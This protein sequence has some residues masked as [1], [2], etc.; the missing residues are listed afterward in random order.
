M[1]RNMANEEGNIAPEAA[2][3]IVAR[4]NK[5]DKK[6]K[7][8]TR[9]IMLLVV[10]IATLGIALGLSSLYLNRSVDNDGLETRGE[11]KKTKVLEVGPSDEAGYGH[12]RDVFG[13]DLSIHSHGDKFT[14][15]NIVDPI[16]GDKVQCMKAGEVAL[17]TVGVEDGAS[18]RLNYKDRVTGVVSDSFTVSDGDFHDNNDHLAFHDDKVKVLFNSNRCNIALSKS[19]S[20]LEEEVGDTVQNEES[21]DEEVDTK[22]GEKN[23][24][25]KLDVEPALQYALDK[26]QDKANHS[27]GLFDRVRNLRDRSRGVPPAQDGGAGVVYHQSEDPNAVIEDP[28]V[29]DPSIQ[30]RQSTHSGINGMTDIGLHNR[31]IYL[32]HRASIRSTGRRMQ[33]DY[34]SDGY[35]EVCSGSECSSPHYHLYADCTLSGERYETTSS[36]VS[37]TVYDA[38]HN[39]D[40][41]IYYAD[42]IVGS[43][44]CLDHTFTIRNEFGGGVFNEETG[45]EEF[46]IRI[47]GGNAL[48]VDHFSLDRYGAPHGRWGANGGGGWC[49]SNDSLEGCWDSISGA[50]Y[51]NKGVILKLGGGSSSSRGPSS[52]RIKFSVGDRCDSDGTCEYDCDYGVSGCVWKSTLVPY[53]PRRKCCTDNP[54]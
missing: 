42:N 22:E 24:D 4:L 30:R 20:P 16:T 8:Q 29:A 31:E 48:G 27:K 45:Y 39:A 51:P 12:L 28:P 25:Y 15:M 13:S 54:W 32:A 17:M 34:D 2:T 3:Q 37:L 1:A 18:V 26:A 19:P 35:L 7:H 53:L 23:D 43:G 9:L 14:A 47:W 46:E 5:A 52:E 11:V 33:Y 10:G 6:S 41:G 38:Y 50:G 36:Q 49:L 40:H 44:G 21:S